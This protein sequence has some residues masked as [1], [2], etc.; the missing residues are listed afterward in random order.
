MSGEGRVLVSLSEGREVRDFLENGLLTELTGAGLAVRIATAAFRVPALTRRFIGPGVEFVSLPETQP[1][2]FLD[3][4]V[5]IRKGLG[6]HPSARLLIEAL[7]RVERRWLHRAPGR[8]D[9]LLAGRPDLLLVLN[10]TPIAEAGLQ[11]SAA[12]AGVRC[13]GVV[14]SWDRLHKYMFSRCEDICVWSDVNRDEAVTLHGYP[15]ERVHVLGAPQ[16]DAYFD[17]ASGRV[18]RSAVCSR[19]GLDPARPYLLLATNGMNLPNHD[20]TYLLDSLLGALRAGQLPA[21]LQVVCRLHPHSRL[22][23]FLQTAGTSGVVFSYMGYLP[24]LGG[25]M[26][27]REVEEF[28]QLIRHAAVV[29]TPGSTLTLEAAIFDVPTVVPVF[30]TYEP[31][32]VGRHFSRRVFGRHFGRLRDRDQAPI[33]S[34][35]EEML[36]LCRRALSE[37]GWYAERRRELVRDYVQFTD[38]QATRRLADLVLR[39]VEAER[40]RRSRPGR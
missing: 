12:V 26:T 11:A 23:H 29:V 15:R 5:R 7:A 13:L 30:H 40:P 22:E 28:A 24:C 36:T 38:G 37:P 31:E 1:G 35:E 2:R 39:L 19:L 9:P 17:P 18:P 16:F 32:R 14:G 10:V 4:S 33:A 8:Y 25:F 3:R 6:R 21:G 20:E 27:R 34:S